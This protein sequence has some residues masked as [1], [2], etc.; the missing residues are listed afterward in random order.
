MNIQERV[1]S[2]LK[3]L[4]ASKGFGATTVEGLASDLSA[5]LTDES[6]DEE[7]TSA[8]NGAMPFFNRMQAENTRYANEIKKKTQQ[9][10]NPAPTEPNNPNPANPEPSGA[11]K[12]IAE[13]AKKVDLLLQQ[14][15]DM[16]IKQ[17]WAKLAEANG[18]T[19]ET[20]INKWQPSQEEDFD[21]AMEELKAFS[22]EFVK[23]AANERSPGKP[24]SGEPGDPNSNKPKDLTASGKE[25]LEGFKKRNESM[26]QK[27]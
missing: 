19:N 4:V 25:A 8:I 23:K 18:I 20:L 24:N 14:N 16:T 11:D 1:L 13:L 17:K 6:T 15:N 12:V 22:K 7:I 5:N 27:K 21:S 2:T 10:A 9:P 26:T 3:P